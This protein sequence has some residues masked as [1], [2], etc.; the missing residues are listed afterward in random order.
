MIPATE[1][2]QMISL[3]LPADFVPQWK[4]HGYTHLHFGAV[5]LALTFHGKKGLPI[6]SRI[7]LLDTR[8]L[9]YEHACIATVQTTLN[10]GTVV[11]T[12][13]P[14]INMTLVDPYLL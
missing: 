2:E 6:V 14:N 10:S 13:F 4:Q 3:D 1:A 11:L 5:R 8:F 7:A 12:F 9:K